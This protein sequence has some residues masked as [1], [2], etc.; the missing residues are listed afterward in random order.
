MWKCKMKNLFIYT[1]TAQKK[2]K[3]S[4]YLSH[5]L[6]RS[7]NTRPHVTHINISI[8]LMS[9]MCEDNVFLY[10]LLFV[11]LWDNL[12]HQFLSLSAVL[13]EHSIYY[14]CSFVPLFVLWLI[15]CLRE[16]RNCTEIYIYNYTKSKVICWRHIVLCWS[17]C[18]LNCFSFLNPLLV[19]CVHIPRI[20]YDN[21]L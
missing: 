1:Y 7:A 3:Q 9:R 13:Q 11:V 17:R 8:T 19:S 10:V 12:C 5:Y 4:I 6:N 15:L 18:A 2:K 21:L 16:F 14:F 20:K